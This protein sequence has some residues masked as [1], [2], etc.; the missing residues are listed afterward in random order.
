MKNR[1]AFSFLAFVAVLISLSSFKPNSKMEEQTRSL[2]A[3]NGV[4]LAYPANVV[5]KQGSN[6]RVRLEGDAEQLAKIETVVKEGHLYIRNKERNLRQNNSRVTIYITVP[7]LEKIAVSGSGQVKGDGTFKNPSLRLAVSGS[8]SIKVAARVEQVTSSI[9]GSG[10]IE[11][12]GEGEQSSASVSGSGT[13]RS[14]D[15]KSNNAK[16]TI[17]GSGR[18]EVHAKSSLKTNISGS[19]K[20]LYEG[21]PNI[22]SRVSGSGTVEKR[23]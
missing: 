17:S 15:F 7:T 5:L 14:F 12:E 4:N 20:V 9:S 16:I 21:K 2:A 19:G 8:G 1:T 3:F 18:C 11:L 6:Q 13:L 22:D 10:S 23:G